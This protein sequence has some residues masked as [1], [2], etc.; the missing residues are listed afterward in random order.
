MLLAELQ[1]SGRELGRESPK[2][3]WK[4][5]GLVSVA[6]VCHYTVIKNCHVQWYLQH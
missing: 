2:E 1:Q 3:Q 5:L 4:D 6:N